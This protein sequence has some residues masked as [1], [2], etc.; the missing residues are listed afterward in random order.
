MKKGFVAMDLGR[1]E[2]VGIHFPLFA[3]NAFDTLEVGMRRY[4]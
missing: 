1:G 4:A 2:T 3:L